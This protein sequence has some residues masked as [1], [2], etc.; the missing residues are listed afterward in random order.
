MHHNFKA[1][2]SRLR[3]A[4]SFAEVVCFSKL[5]EDALK[6]EKANRNCPK[7]KTWLRWFVVREFSLRPAPNGPGTERRQ[8]HWLCCS[9]GARRDRCQRADRRRRSRRR[10]HGRCAQSERELWAIARTRSL[11]FR[12]RRIDARWPRSRTTPGRWRRICC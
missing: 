12:R 8:S 2:L 1:Q 6:L 4:V 7:W 3:L 10:Y 11:P 9:R 5:T